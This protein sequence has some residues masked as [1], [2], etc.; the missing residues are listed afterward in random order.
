MGYLVYKTFMP[1]WRHEQEDA[2]GKKRIFKVG[3]KLQPLRIK[4]G[5]GKIYVPRSGY[6]Y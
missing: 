6:G 2:N 5:S 1:P 4:K 3:Q